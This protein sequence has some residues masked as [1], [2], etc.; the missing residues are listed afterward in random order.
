MF[1]SYEAAWLALFALIALGASVTL[2]LAHIRGIYRVT[3][4][5]IIGAMSGTNAV[6]VF[7]KFEP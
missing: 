5:A 2:W 4:I 6:L 3:K 7:K 1:F